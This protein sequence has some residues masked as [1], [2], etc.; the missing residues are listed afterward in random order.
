MYR[1][2]GSDYA[3]LITIC[4][5]VSTL[6]YLYIRNLCIGSAV[7]VNYLYLIKIINKYDRC[8]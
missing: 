1:M 3:L 6:K 8:R 4:P 5:N 2:L 7:L